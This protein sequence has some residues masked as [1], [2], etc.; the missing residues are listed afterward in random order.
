[1]CTPLP[2]TKYYEYAK[3]HGFLHAKCWEDYSNIHFIH[4]K[5]VV[6]TEELTQDDLK[7]A[8][9]YANNY[10]IYRLYLRKALTEPKWTIFKLTDTYRRHGLNTFNLL[11]RAASRVVK[12]RLS[13]QW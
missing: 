11:Y 3:E 13:K 5:P 7:M 2:G 1:V 9:M 10:L 6:S 8:S 12:N 4:D